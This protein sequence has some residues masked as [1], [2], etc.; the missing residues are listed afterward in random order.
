MA[1]KQP[2]A[3]E[4]PASLPAEVEERP[5]RPADPRAA[6]HAKVVDLAMKRWRRA[7]PADRE[8]RD[9]AYADL[10]FLE[11]PGAQWGEDAK[12]ARADRPCLEFNRLPTTIAQI[13]G[14][15][16]QMRP[17]IKV[18]PVDSRGDPD[19]ADVIA[20][21]VRYI[22]NRSD[23]ASAYFS[24]A[25]QQVACGIGHWKVTTE[26]GSDSTFE[27]EIRITHVPD[28]IGVRWDPDAVLPT[29]EDA[30]FCF[31]PVDMSRE[32]FEETYPDKPAAEIGD[33]VLHQQGLSEWSTADT[34]RVCE[35]WTKTPVKKTLALMPDG[36]ILD[37][38]D[39]TDLQAYDERFERAQ[40]AGARIEVREGHKVERYIISATDV[41]EG[42][43]PWPGRFIPV[44]PV[45]GIEMQVGKRR[46]RRGV[47][48]LAKD[49]QRAYNYARSTQIEVVALQPKAP[50]TGTATMFKGYEAVWETANTVNHPFLPYNPD[51][52]AAGAAPQRVPPPVPSAGLAELTRDASEDMKAVTGVYDASLGARSNE[53]SGKA[54]KARQQEGD[55]GSFVYI[56]NFSRAIRHTGS[57]VVDLI[58]H[59]YDTARTLRI[60]GE[61]GKVDLVSINQPEGLA[62]DDVAE[63]IQN[64]VTVGAYDVAMEM[65]PSYTTRRE[66]ALDGM[67]QLV[68]AAPQLAPMILDLLA[69]AQDWPMADKIA[70]RIRTMLPPQIQAEE[71][72]ESGEPPP[73]PPPPSPQEQAA[74]A[75][76][77]RQQQLEEGRQQLDLAKLGLEKDKLQADVMK[78]QA[79]LQKA[80]IDA[81]ARAIE[82]SRPP[83]PQAA[84]APAASTAAPATDPR[85][86]AI[87]EA[88]QQ[89][90]AVV[91]MILEEM[92]PPEAPPPGPDG[93]PGA[94]PQIPG[95]M[96][97]I[98]TEAPQGAFSFDPSA[99]GLP[100]APE[101]MG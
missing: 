17:A 32:V 41:L 11:V 37:L 67:I 50:F 35:Y 80:H 21:M 72:Q 81:E 88:V 5:E 54:I 60:V 87:T 62:D 101:M 68:Q 71:A 19:T 51:P 84:A 45:I 44:V 31:V 40:V 69:K 92:A 89:L 2:R 10:E 83:E 18:V 20:G 63:R 4:R 52:M 56:V 65:G 66:A 8:N 22:E 29:R 25:D 99:M 55:V 98:P 47:V 93:L 34:V 48:R 43:T 70:K 15:I 13:T 94:D 7:D 14:D 61:D 30:R 33:G 46:Y 59:I 58:P 28:G 39:K 85:L 90:G 79:E 57:I 86:D 12:R 16:R 77:Q 78:I 1:K 38:T 26:Y 27:Q 9:N 97:T 53:T 42:P 6:D 49:P 23:A 24:A 82:A 74:M 64:D 75:Q 96:P 100:A 3:V 91:S 36:E 95:D 76:Q 73:A